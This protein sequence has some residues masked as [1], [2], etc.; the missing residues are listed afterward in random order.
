[1]SLATSNTYSST[2]YCVISQGDSGGPLTVIDDD[3]V[4]TQVGVASFVSA[5]GCHTDFPAGEL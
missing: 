4:L 1:M 5:S 3:G 2:V